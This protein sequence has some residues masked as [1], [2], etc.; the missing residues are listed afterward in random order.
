MRPY[1]FR[2]DTPNSPDSSSSQFGCTRRRF[3]CLHWIRLSTGASLGRR[4]R[5]PNRTGGPSNHSGSP[6]GVCP[7]HSPDGVT[8]QREA[9]LQNRTRGR[10]PFST[11]REICRTM[12]QLTFMRHSETTRDIRRLAFWQSQNIH[13]SLRLFRIFHP[14]TTTVILRGALDHG[15]CNKLEISGI[16]SIN[17]FHSKQ[18]HSVFATERP[19]RSS[20]S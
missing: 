13:Q 6:G 9:A 18:V 8:R 19:S 12:D 7:P 5:R 14:Y 3:G 17:H 4:F 16:R 10:F 1:P 11:T 20:A 2:N 15:S